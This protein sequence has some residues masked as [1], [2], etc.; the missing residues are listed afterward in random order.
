MGD[1]FF[2]QD[3]ATIN[4]KTFKLVK[5]RS[6]VKDAEKDTGAIWATEND[7]RVTPIGRFLRRFWIDEL[8]QLFNV[9]KGDM[10]MVGP[11][12]ERPIFI[13]EFAET[14]PDFHYRMTVKAGVT[15][16][17]QV[18]GKYSTSPENKIKFD[19]MYIRKSSFMYDVKII[20]ETV[21]KILMG[22][23]RRGENKDLEFSELIS[24]FNIEVVR[25]DNVF[26]FEYKDNFTK[27]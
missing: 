22:T 21:K 11:R 27:G 12:P 26:I 7:P 20:A 15:G 23:L 13:E 25:E 19:L 1:L 6:M 16:L 17:A 3:R 14:I 24:L 10:S 5:F 9:L 8:P 2:Q 18:L 4:N